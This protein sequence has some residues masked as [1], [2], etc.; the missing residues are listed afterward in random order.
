MTDDPVEQT[1]ATYDR[2]AEDY[3]R[4][5]QQPS[6]ELLAFR[7][8]FAASVSGPVADLGCGPGR[9]LGAFRAAG[10]TA[11]G[12]DLSSGMLRRAARAGLP[13]VRGDLRRPPLR[14]RTLDGIWSCAALL[15]VPRPDVPA[16]LAAWHALLRPGGHLAL[17]TS[18]G[19]D[20]G[21]EL[22]P[23]E[24][25]GPKG[26]ALHRWFVH[27]DEAELLGLLDSAGFTVRS[28]EQ[29]AGHR[30]WTMIRATASP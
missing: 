27:H 26:G 24:G 30:N 11:L 10:I 3:D 28:H 15:H 9:D 6:A 5:T 17:S 4:T 25:P 2:V 19:D 8:A 14:P 20:E 29:R 22:V 13:V 1:R 23:Y 7:A 21:W 16:T 12:V 18:L